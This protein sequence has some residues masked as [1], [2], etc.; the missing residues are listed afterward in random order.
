MTKEERALKAK[1]ETEL[2]SKDRENKELRKINSQLVANRSEATSLAK[3]LDG[4]Y[5]DVSR[6]ELLQSQR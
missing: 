3:R 2:R 6:K 1:L 4:D 5:L